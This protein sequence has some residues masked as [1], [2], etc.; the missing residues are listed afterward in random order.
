MK[1]LKYIFNILILSI[2]F[3]SCS[4]DDD[5]ITAVETN[6]VEDLNLL[7]EISAEGHTLQMYS[8][9]EQLEVGYNEISILIK[10]LETNQYV[11]NAS[12]TWMPM[13]NMETMSHSAPHTLLNNSEENSVYKAYIVFQ[14]PNNDSERWELKLDY[15]FKEQVLEKII[16]LDVVSPIDGLKKTQ[17]FTGSDETRYIMA[18]VNPK[19]FQVAQN[20]FEMVLYKMENMNTFPVV[21]DYKITLDPRMPSMGNHSSPN[22]QDLTYN[23]ATQKY[24]GVLSLTMT[25]YWKINLKLLNEND[26]VLKGEEVT[27]TQSESS[28]YM[29]LEL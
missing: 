27:E 25:G 28:L 15:T 6:P 4:S 2:F 18:Y 11:T 14:M 24:E 23:I 12:P 17:V 29:E 3:G 13:M 8:E 16:D 5:E 7:Y 19:K 10:D 21:E 20:E 1:N 9:K 22:N 26:E